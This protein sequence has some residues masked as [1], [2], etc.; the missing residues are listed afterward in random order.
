MGATEMQIL[1]IEIGFKNV[2]STINLP[3]PVNLLVSFNLSVIQ[4]DKFPPYNILIDG[5]CFD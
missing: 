1:H 2:V 5:L 3:W 4:N